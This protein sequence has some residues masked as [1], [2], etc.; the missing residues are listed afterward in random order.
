M[1]TESVRSRDMSKSKTLGPYAKVLGDIFQRA[2]K[3][4]KELP[5]V[6]ASNPISIFRGDSL[7]PKEIQFMLDL[8]IN[9]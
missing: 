9:G 4:R 2:S 3:N 6:V 8:Y 5:P 7:T 1:L